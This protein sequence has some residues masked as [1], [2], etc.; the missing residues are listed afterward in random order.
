V[1]GRVVEVQTEGSYLCVE[2]GFLKVSLR[3]EER[4]RVPLDDICALILS[5]HGLSHSS[6]LFTALAE[7]GCPVVFCG[8]NFRPVGLLWPVESHHREARR[9]DA[10]LTAKRPLRK[11]LWRQVVQLKIGMQACALDVLGGPAAVLRRMADK[12]Q[13]GDSGNVEGQAARLY[14]PALMGA[15]FRRNPDLD[16]ANAQLNYGYAIVR[17]MVARHLMGAGLH[18]GLPIH[19]ANEGNAMRLV[20]DLMEPFRPFVDVLV[21]QMLGLGWVAVDAMSKERLGLL[22]ATSI[23]TSEGRSPL[24]LVCERWCHSLASVYLGES[25]ELSFPRPEPALL[26]AAL[27][28]GTRRNAAPG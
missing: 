12:V 15:A 11:R 28:S 1:I 3:G 17:A 22:P 23:P 6:N 27:A 14:W 16:G 9:M 20:D 24:S 21:H 7:R 13:P 5:A 10:Q 19:H 26:K 4:G 8:P 2:R 18:P 25:R